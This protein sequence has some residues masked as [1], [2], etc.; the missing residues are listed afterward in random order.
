MIRQRAAMLVTAALA[1]G[2]VA[3][4]LLWSFAREWFWPSLLPKQWSLRA[5]QYVF[6]GASG[7]GAATALSFAIAILVTLVALAIAL[8]AARALAF[9]RF[10]GRGL[11]LFLILLPV[12]APPLA[13]A[14]GIHAIF[15]RLGLADSLAGVILVHLVPAVPYA[16]LVLLGSFLRLDR[17]YEAQARTLGATPTAVWR[18]VTIPAILPG[19]L[20]AASFAFLI[21]WSQYLL[22]LL[23]GGGRV[24]TLPLQVVAF[25]RGGDQAVAAALSLVFLLPTLLAFGA[26]ARYRSG[27]E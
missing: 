1:I 9:H 8:P 7:I 5:W 22:T 18:H 17:D 27:H 15:L 10:Q 24:L 4:L 20:V 6:A 14:M 2:P 21:S 19:L 11:F 3:V 16:T 25:Q 12:L 13:S 23:I 26:T